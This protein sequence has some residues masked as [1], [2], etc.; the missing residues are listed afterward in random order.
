MRVN[1]AKFIRKYLRFFRIVFDIKPQYNV[2][3]DGNFIF[4]AI[5]YKLDI[6]ERLTKLLQSI[7]DVK[8]FVQKSVLDELKAVGAKASEALEF[9]GKFCSVIEDSSISGDTPASR[10]I[11]MLDNLNDESSSIKSSLRYIVATQDKDLRVQLASIAGVPLVYFNKVTLVLEPPSE[12]SRKHSNKLEVDKAS[13]KESELDVLTKFKDSKVN[14][15][16]GSNTVVT[17]DAAPGASATIVTKLRQKRKSL[18]ANPLSVRPASQ[19]SHKSQRRK[20]QKF[21]RG[22]GP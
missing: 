18:S 2:I 3:L 7:I 22:G 1:R 20:V 13:L 4:Q 19:D 11:Y 6:I 14:V 21:R 9:A 15:V 12:A 8:L 17:S 16:G 5:K 10:L